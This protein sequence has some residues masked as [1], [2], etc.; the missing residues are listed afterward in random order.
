[1][2]EAAPSRSKLVAMSITPVA[3]ADPNTRLGNRAILQQP[4]PYIGICGDERFYSVVNKGDIMDYVISRKAGGIL[5]GNVPSRQFD[6]D[7]NRF[8]VK[9]ETKYY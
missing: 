1:M 4:K 9:V 3:W 7:L 8:G 6:E 2:E 5:V